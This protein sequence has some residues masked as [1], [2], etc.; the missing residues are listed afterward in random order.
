[1][2]TT[3]RELL[4]CPFCG[5]S[6]NI[7]MTNE[8]HDHSGG[9]F[10]ACPVC[11]ASTALVYACGDDPRPILVDKWNRR[12]HLAEPQ[13]DAG[14]LADKL[15]HDIQVHKLFWLATGLYQPPTMKIERWREAIAALRS[16]PAGTPAWAVKGPD[17][18]VIAA[19]AKD[20]MAAWLAAG[21]KFDMFG[22]HY[23]IDKGYACVPVLIVEVKP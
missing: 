14:R 19:S 23:Y 17:G 7:A 8:K 4:P 6:K 1:M 5:N 13:G 2:S 9:Y 12:A 21:I 15:E 11:D 20:E 10:I 16:Q 3:D 22:R 18:E